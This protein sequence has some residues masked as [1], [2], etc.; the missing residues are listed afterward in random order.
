MLVLAIETSCD[1][2]GSRGIG[3]EKDPSKWFLR[4]VTSTRIWGVVPELALETYRVHRAI[5]TEGA[6]VSQSYFERIDR[7]CCTQGPLSRSLPGA[8]VCQIPAFASGLPFVGQSYWGSSFSHFLEKEETSEI[9]FH[10]MVVSE[11][12]PSLFVWRGSEN[13]RDWDKPEMTRQGR[14]SIRCQALGLG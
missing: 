7:H 5:V 2:T 8:L 4:Q 1:D 3:W 6:G 14:L 12:I 11:A 10:R 13:S 9:S